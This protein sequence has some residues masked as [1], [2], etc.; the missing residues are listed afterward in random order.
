MANSSHPSHQV[1][2]DL[3]N[4]ELWSWIEEHQGESVAALRLKYGTSEPYNSAIAQIEARQKYSSKFKNLFGEKWIFPSG[5]ALEQSS[6]LATAAHKA[7]LF[8]TPYSAD[9]CAGMGIDSRA[10][11]LRE[12]CKKH[13]CFEQNDGLAA[14]LRHNLKKSTVVPTPF[15]IQ[16]LENWIQEN[17]VLSNELTVYLDPDRR[18]NH[19]RTSSIEEGTPNLIDIQE[20]LLALA[21]KVITKHSPM[22]DIHECTR[23][24]VDLESIHIVQYQ[25]ECK[26]IITVQIP[27]Y[28]H[29]PYIVA[30]EAV[31][32]QSIEH[33]YPINY[34]TEHGAIDKFLIQPSAV[35]NKSE[36]HALL[37]FIYGWKRL[38]FGNLYTSDTLPEQSPFYKVFNVTT[39]FESLKKIR[40]SG[41]YAIE[42]I[43]SKITAKDLRKRLKLKEGR[44][45]KL[46]Y[47][48]NG[49]TKLIVEGLLIE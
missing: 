6:S 2:P 29:A 22:V 41:E 25:G 33:V 48:Q 17:N 13:L 24:L 49:R 14:L 42:S 9:L 12:R 16:S 43:G 26:E 39:T 47:L 31:T 5:L 20:S 35:S 40:L 1:K 19:A 15:N 46:F 37:A 27:G 45:Q 3:L 23:K 32:G 7:S 34:S 30:V 44:A 10:I 11:T 38:G 18:A 36:L 8:T 28:N 4:E 21:D